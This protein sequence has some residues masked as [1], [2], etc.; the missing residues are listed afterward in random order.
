MQIPIL[1]GVYTNES[2]DYR[3]S[4]PRNLVPVP[5]DNGISKGY[6]R[7][8][9]GLVKF[10]DGIGVDRGGI[11]WND[12]CYR[13]MGSKLV[14]IGADGV[15]TIIG[16]VGN[17]GQVSLDYSFDYLAIASGKKLFL[18]DGSTLTQVTDPDLG[19]VLD[20][21]WIDGYFMTTDGE[22]LVI[23]ELA[24]PFSVNPLKYGSSEA[25]PD[26]VKGLLKLRNEVYAFNRYTIEVFDNVGAAN[27]PFQRVPG[28]QIERGAI[29]THTACIFMETIAFLGSGLNEAP[30]IWLGNNSNSIKISTREID[31]ILAD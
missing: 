17:G 28:A 14:K 5:Q 26:E 4:Y 12:V 20:V 13:V 24:D 30:A 23:T 9:N 10:G 6:L 2:P 18:Y 25:S 11:N 19:I 27:F 15:S 16:D 7:P 29:G 1:H 21:T 8:S 3:V 22:F 31:Q